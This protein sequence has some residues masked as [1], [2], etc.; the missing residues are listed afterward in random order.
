MPGIDRQ[1]FVRE[2]ID[3]RQGTKSAAVGHLIDDKVHAPNIV[4]RAY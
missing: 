3:H 1:T 2:Q 4:A